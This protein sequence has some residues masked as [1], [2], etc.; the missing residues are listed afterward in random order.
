MGGLNSPN[1]YSDGLNG[2]GAGGDFW[3][4]LSATNAELDALQEK[5]RSVSQ[6]H[7]QILVSAKSP[8]PVAGLS[9]AFVNKSAAA[10][11][12]RASRDAGALFDDKRQPL[13]EQLSALGEHS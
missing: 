4:Q 12:D 10:L 2:G 6:A 11:G 1:P 7:Q 3:S 9:T 8:V 13:A 5:I